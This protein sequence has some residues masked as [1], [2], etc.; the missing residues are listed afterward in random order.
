MICLFNYISKLV[1]FTRGKDRL[2]AR[3]LQIL[4]SMVLI[5]L[6]SASISAQI[7]SEDFES[8]TV[9]SNQGNG[10]PQKW[11][12][13]PPP[14]MNPDSAWGVEDRYNNHEFVGRNLSTAGTWRSEYVDISSNSP[15]NISVAI[16]D[17][18]VLEESGIDTLSLYYRINDGAEILWHKESGNF[19]SSYITVTVGG[20]SGDS[21]QVIIRMRNGDTD[22]TYMFDDVEVHEQRTLYSITDGNWNTN[23][24]WSLTRIGGSCGCT[25]DRNDNVFIQATDVVNITSDALATNITV[26]NGGTLRWTVGNNELYIENGGK[27]EVEGTGTLTRN[28]QTGANIRID[29]EWKDV[30]IVNNGT[31]SVS[32]IQLENFQ[33]NVN[34]S[35]SGDIDLAANLEITGD[36]NAFDAEHASWG[37]EIWITN[38]LTGNLNIT[39]N[40]GVAATGSGNLIFTNN[41]TVDQEG[42]ISNV[43]VD[44]R[45]YNAANAVWNYGG[46]TPVGN[47]QLYANYSNSSLVFFDKNSSTN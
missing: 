45:F 33:G 14:S 29:D 20:L 46:S 4:F 30:Q 2:S 27:L 10:A 37:P 12:T 6:F 28:G 13:T 31:F 18:G 11:T 40:L 19:S 41:G 42:S 44:S 36:G 16:R 23:G 43:T 8:D 35:G 25:P 32:S 9:G 1:D 26:E 24:T 15:V 38:D 34:L 47:I 17:S 39:G 5:S 3:M 22:E 21:I 7:W